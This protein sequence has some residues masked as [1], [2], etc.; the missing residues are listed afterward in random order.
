MRVARELPKKT[1][2]LLKPNL[3][4]LGES[5][6]DNI[7]LFDRSKGRPIQ[8]GDVFTFTTPD[9]MR[10]PLPSFKLL[11]MR[12]HFQRIAALQGALEDDTA[13]DTGAEDDTGAEEDT[14][15]EDDADL[16]DDTDPNGDGGSHGQSQ[17]H[18]K[19]HATNSHITISRTGT[20]SS[21]PKAN[22]GNEYHEPQ[23]FWGYDDASDDDCIGYE[24]DDGYSDASEGDLEDSHENDCECSYVNGYD[25]QYDDGFEEDEF[26]CEF[27]DGF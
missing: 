18:P 14:G 2:L 23:T 13:N 24:Y 3:L 11:E 16:E 17:E 4:I 19:V 10:L 5:P 22:E 9:P 8:S 12:W 26:G 6:G 21:T 15:S 1:P 27:D 20:A 7:G 25:S